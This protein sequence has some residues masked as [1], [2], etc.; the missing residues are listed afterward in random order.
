M[1]LLYS[2]LSSTTLHLPVAQDA[3]P[4]KGQPEILT[5]RRELSTVGPAPFPMIQPAPVAAVE[6]LIVGRLAKGLFDLS[7][8]CTIDGLSKIHFLRRAA[9]GKEHE[10]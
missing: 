7:H 8:C 5:V 10:H 6:G 2:L 1:R 4:V 9:P 3:F